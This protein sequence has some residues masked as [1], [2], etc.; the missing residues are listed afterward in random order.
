MFNQPR[1]A[2]GGSGWVSGNSLSG[3]VVQLCPVLA[4]DFPRG[5]PR[6]E[7]KKAPL[8]QVVKNSPGLL[9]AGEI[10]SSTSANTGTQTG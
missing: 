5:F 8:V 4:L 6:T 1:V 3:T 2:L 10:P 9:W 7:A